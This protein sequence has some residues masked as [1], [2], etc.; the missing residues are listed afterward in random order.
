MKKFIKS[1]VSLVMVVVLVLSVSIMPASAAESED[2][3]VELVSATVPEEEVA[4]PDSLIQIIYFSRSECK[5]IYTKMTAYT[6][7]DAS[8][9]Q[10]LVNTIGHG[11]DLIVSLNYNRALKAFYDG[12]Y[13]SGYTG[14]MMYVY[15]NASP[16]LI[17][18]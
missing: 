16:A 12:G 11:V 9:V 8:F 10:W 3:A 6:S 18:Y 15:D 2:E 5:T 1:T 7:W 17:A 14:C 4:N 13:G